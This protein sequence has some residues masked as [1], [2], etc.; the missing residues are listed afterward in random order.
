MI[1][2]FGKY[3]NLFLKVSLVFS[4]GI[5]FTS[6]TSCPIT[7]I[8]TACVNDADCGQN[9]GSI[10]GVS[11]TSSSTESVLSYEWKDANGNVLQYD[12]D[13]RD[14]VNVPPGDYTLTIVYHPNQNNPPPDC[15][16][17]NA[18]PSQTFT[19]GEICCNT[20]SCPN[21]N[22]SAIQI[23]D[24]DCGSSNGSVSNITIQNE[25]GSEVFTWTDDMGVTVGNT[26]NLSGV[27]AGK[28]TLSISGVAGCNEVAGPFT[29]DEVGC[30][31]SS[32]F[33]TNSANIQIMNADCGSSNGNISGITIQ[34]TSNS[35]IFTW[36][37][38]AGAVVGNNIDLSGVTSGK[39]TLAIT[40]GGG[41]TEV[42]G[43][44][45]IDEIGCPSGACVNSDPSSVQITNGDCGVSNGSIVGIVLQNAVG[46]EVFTW[47]NATG[48][49][50]SNTLDLTM[51]SSGQYTLTVSGPGNCIEIAGPFTIQEVGCPSAQ[52]LN[53]DSS[54]IQITNAE[55]GQSDGY[56]SGIVIP[57][58]S[59]NE[60]YSWI[61][62]N[63][64]VVGSSIDLENQPVGEYT[65]IITNT[66]GAIE[67]AGPFCI[68]ENPCS[69][70][71]ITI[72]DINVVLNDAD[73]NTANGSILG[74]I[75][76]GASS[77]VSY[78][79]RNIDGQIVSSSL[80]L[81]D[82]TRGEYILT[83]TANG[84]SLVDGPF[85][86]QS[87]NDCNTDPPVQNVSIKAATVMT[88]NGDGSN[89]MFMIIGLENYPN[90]RL[91]VF[92]RW[93]NK[94]YEA[95]NYQNNWFGNYQNK[96]LPI[97]AYYYIL[98][99]RGAQPQTLKGSITIMK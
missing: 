81:T 22:P 46:N 58:S 18:N 52:C 29:I 66:S 32:C 79:W 64:Q 97:G 39:Y 6:C 11:W 50:V 49:T 47:T 65:L 54:N 34:N 93:G 12:P 78:E 13:V 96:P 7:T 91:Y 94:V 35:E 73:N 62:S 15:S 77:D 87:P 3:K 72:N 75:V 61:D 51:V 70:C 84:C 69:N 98:E 76:N 8:N 48:S 23:T 42:E 40:D 80:D 17:S 31:T 45:T 4:L 68:N 57:N 99:I 30:T 60:S 53:S 2:D 74:I 92:N 63:N 82:V 43:P 19:I 88:P 25:T 5:L 83:V 95:S 1:G 55:C 56:I 16:S 20:G 85:Y 10:T 86:I 90:N 27:P 59:G 33:N 36:V 28:Y 26:V 71:P 14:L 44:F 21:T 38:E 24:A 37:N 9:N 41:C 67:I 89:D